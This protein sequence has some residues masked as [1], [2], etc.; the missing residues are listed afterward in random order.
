[1]VQNEKGN[2]RP[3]E[4]NDRVGEWRGGTVWKVF[5]FSHPGFF[6]MQKLRGL[7]T[8][9]NCRKVFP[10]PSRPT[11]NLSKVVSSGI[12]QSLSRM[13]FHNLEMISSQMKF[14]S[15][16]PHFS[17]PQSSGLSYDIRYLAHSASKTWPTHVRQR[18]SLRHILQ[19]ARNCSNFRD[20]HWPNS[21]RPS[22]QLYD[23]CT[24]NFSL[25]II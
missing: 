15:R 5:H 7:L 24:W 25:R 1:M 4:W 11:G 17:F 20:F 18:S 2:K 21:I 16:F 3:K 22:A 10:S 14:H 13:S 9:V 8:T 19:E 23:D 6:C 12:F